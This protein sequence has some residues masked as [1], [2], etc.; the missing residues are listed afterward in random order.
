MNIVLA[1]GIFEPEAGG[2]ATYTKELARLLTEHGHIVTVVTY[3]AQN[4]YEFDIEYPFTVVRVTR[5]FRILNYL[6]YTWQLFCEAKQADYLYAFDVVS[7]G[8]P[9]RVVSMMRRVPYIVRVGGSY[10]WERYLDAGY[11]PC[12]LAEFYATK[13][14]KL[15]PFL[16]L[17]TSWVL[18]GA[19]AVVFNSNQQKEIYA[20]VYP[21]S[22]EQVREVIVNPGYE[23]PLG[24]VWTPSEDVKEIIFWE[25]FIVMKNIEM[26][27]QAYAASQTTAELVLIGDGPRKE[28][29]IRLIE[30]YEIGDRVK[31]F[32]S[33]RRELILKRAL[34]AR[35]VVVPSW[36]D[37]SPN[38]INECVALGIP[39]LITKENFLPYAIPDIL[40]IDPHQAHSLTEKIVRLD[41]KLAYEETVAACKSIS[42][43]YSW[44]QCARDHEKLF[45]RITPHHE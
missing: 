22:R 6:N 20:N 24:F 43:S 27:L 12:T 28:E 10:V 37:V 39:F 45:S 31:V 15:F 38:Q 33:Q 7:A 19:R 9:A 18:R 5:R 21:A 29:I 13:K 36:T 23:N 14:N 34:H 42:F 3:S 40:T 32:P 8:I 25:R 41:E 44:E 35:Y 2:P 26:L 30:E 11:A 17:C 4:A 16:T 1:T